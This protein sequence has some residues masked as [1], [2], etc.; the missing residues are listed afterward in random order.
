MSS[1]I[2]RFED[3][4]ATLPTTGDTKHCPMCGATIKAVAKKCRF[5]GESLDGRNSD[6][7]VWRLGKQLVMR[8]DAKLPDRCV[9]TNEPA[10]RWLT[11]RLYWHHPLLYLLILA[12]VLFYAIAAIIVREKAVID[13][14]LSQER[15]SRRRWS[16]FGAWVVAFSG[17]GLCYLGIQFAAGGEAAALIIGGLFLALLSGV[18]GASL[19]SVVQPARITADYVWIKGVHPAYLD[20]LPEFPGE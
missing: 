12:G 13:V 9:K 2:Q 20:A 19:S 16:I 1:E 14:G 11:R 8:K 15:F 7:G 17:L 6:V 18:V 4:D 3:L 5:C 10:E